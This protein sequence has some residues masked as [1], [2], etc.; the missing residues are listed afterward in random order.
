MI[1]FLAGKE[2]PESSRAWKSS[3]PTLEK[4]NLAVHQLRSGQSSLQFLKAENKR[5]V[6][7]TFDSHKDF[8]NEM[9]VSSYLKGCPFVLQPIC[10]MSELDEI[11]YHQALDGD[12]LKY[13]H[14]DGLSYNDLVNICAQ[15]VQG[16]GAI[17]NVGYLHMDIK[18]ENIV[19]EGRSIWLIDLGLASPIRTAQRKVGTPRTMSPECLLGWARQMPISVASDWW[20]V[21]VTI[22][23]LFARF[24]Q[25][26]P[27]THYKYFPYRILYNE[28]GEAVQF[29]WPPMP[30]FYFP[31]ALFDLLFGYGGLLSFSFS[32]RLYD[33]LTLLKHPFFN[34]QHVMAA[35]PWP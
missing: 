32:A 17:H 30:P 8:Q 5:I 13:R 24:F 18:P 28:E 33:P 35:S 31:P 7:K 19:R 34:N 16:I 3:Y 9:N 20:S 12:L 22:F 1:R 2:C 29:Q 6:V 10:T 15:I 26:P 27:N 11:V 25:L 21:G 4:T 14:S 23:Y